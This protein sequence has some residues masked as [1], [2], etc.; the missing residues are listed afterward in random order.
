MPRRDGI[1]QLKAEDQPTGPMHAVTAARS[2]A[3]DAT[4]PN[5]APL[6]GHVRGR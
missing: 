4:A 2:V 3:Q 1:T 5:G 6:Y